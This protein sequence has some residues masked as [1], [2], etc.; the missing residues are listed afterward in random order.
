MRAIS[1]LILDEGISTRS[2]SAWLALR[3][4]VSMSPMGSFTMALPAALG[5]ARDD[6]LMR[7]LAQADAADPELAEVRPRPP[8]TPAPGVVARRELLGLRMLDYEC[9]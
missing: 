9:F 7:E 5:H 2:C 3:M 8:A 6:A 4:R 1:T